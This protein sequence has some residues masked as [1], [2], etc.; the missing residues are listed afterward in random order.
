MDRTPNA[1]AAAQ[2]RTRALGEL[3]RN[4]DNHER[5]MSSLCAVHNIVTAPDGQCVLCRRPKLRLA[6]E[7]ES[8]ASK[9]VTTLLG[10]CML[11]TMGFVAYTLVVPSASASSA[12]RDGARRRGASGELAGAPRVELAPETV[13]EAATEGPPPS[14]PDAP[15]RTNAV[16]T[17]A[18]AEEAARAP[19]PSPRGK[20]HTSVRTVGKR[21]ADPRLIEARKSVRVTMYSAPWC[22]ICDRARRFLEAREVELSDH[23]VDA[24][25]GA[26]RR[27]AQ[28]NPAA[29]IPTFVVDGKTIVGFHP[30]G[31]EDAI[32]TAAQQRYCAKHEQGLVCE[33]IASAR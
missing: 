18:P 4:K 19:E 14:A 31:L 8:A 13:L 30:W 17:G 22:F 21:I 33:R 16:S 6:S 15:P 28:L 32:D 1:R 23:N 5:R 24:D 2:R 11:A 9:A 20:A 27:L 12:G 3:E 7:D 10:L 25:E 26:E 29:S